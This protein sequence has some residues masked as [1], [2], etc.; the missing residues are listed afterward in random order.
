MFTCQ[1]LVLFI[2]VADEFGIV[3][4]ES[5]IPIVTDTISLV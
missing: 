4:R 2:P 1:L 3:R 5:R